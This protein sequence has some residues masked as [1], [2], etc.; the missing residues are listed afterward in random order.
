M[1]DQLQRRRA[2]AGVLFGDGVGAGQRGQQKGLDRRPV[3]RP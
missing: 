1:V 2:A 3:S